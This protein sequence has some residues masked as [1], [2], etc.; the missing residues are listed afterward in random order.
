MD[1]RADLTPLDVQRRHASE[2]DQVEV[3]HTIRSA[4]LDFSFNRPSLFKQWLGNAVGP[5]ANDKINRLSCI[6]CS[7]KLSSD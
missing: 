7:V 4:A 3:F 1:K 2:T 5:W 6:T